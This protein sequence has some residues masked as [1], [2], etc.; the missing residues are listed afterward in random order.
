MQS[1]KRILIAT[2]A[3]LMLVLSIG[4]ML[5]GTWEAERSVVIR[6][7]AAA[8]FPYLNNLRQWQT[9]V[10]WTRQQPEV[11][12]EYSGPDTGAGSTS[13]WNNRDGRTVMKIMQTERNSLVA[14]TALF[15]AGELRTDGHLSLT[16][17]VEGTR[18]VWHA[19]GISGRG[20]GSSYLALF[21]GRRNSQAIAESLENLKKKLE[22]KP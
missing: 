5:P 7:P 11:Q 21:E 8:I 13:R 15:N 1:L 3:I 22:T 16:S 10:V 19:T 9:W 6:A 17:T 4:Y 14:Y 20:P 18:L 12:I 2:I